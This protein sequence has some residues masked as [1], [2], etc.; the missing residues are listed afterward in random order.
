MP[1]WRIDRLAHRALPLVVAL[2]AADD[3]VVYIGIGGRLHRLVEHA[4]RHGARMQAEARKST[5]ARVQLRE[6]LRGTRTAFDLRTRPHGTTFQRRAWKAL[7]EI[8]FGETCSYGAQAVAA[9][10]P[11]GARAVGRAN[12]ANPIPIVIPCHRVLGSSGSMVGFSG[13]GVETKRWLLALEREGRAP[14]WTPAQRSA[15]RASVAQL[16]LF[17]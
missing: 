2:D 16:G 11:G 4:R 5:A 6:Y 1:T 15:R 17:A 13:G 3:A 9:G 14:E 12:G 8:P 7:T 10:Q